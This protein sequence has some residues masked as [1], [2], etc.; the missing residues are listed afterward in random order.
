MD[1]RDED[2]VQEAMTQ[3]VCYCIL[4]KYNGSLFFVPKLREPLH[5]VNPTKVSQR[6]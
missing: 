1:R 6:C 5:G 4:H 3:Q 2:R